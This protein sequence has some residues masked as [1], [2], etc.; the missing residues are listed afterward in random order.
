VTNEALTVPTKVRA[1]QIRPATFVAIVVSMNERSWRGRW[2]V[3]E[4]PEVAV[5]G[6]LYCAED[7]RLRLELVGG[8]DTK[9]RAPLPGGGHTVRSESRD[10]PLI[11]G[12]S[13]SKRFTLIRAHAA[14]T[15]GVGLFGDDIV[16]QTMNPNRVLCGIHLESLG[17]PQFVR[18]HLQLERLLHWSAQS[19]FDLCLLLGENGKSIRE[20]KAATHQVPTVTASFNGM[21]I[22]L[23]VRSTEFYVVDSPVANSRSMEVTERAILD[24][25]TSEPVSFDA[26]DAIGKDMQDLLTLSAYEP[27][28]SRA[29]SL[30]FRAASEARLGVSDTKEVEVMGRQVFQTDLKEKEKQH[31][32]FLFT[33]DDI[34]FSQ[35]VPRWLALKKSASL[36]FNILFGLRYIGSGYVGPRLL[37][38]ATAAENIHRALCSMSAPLPRKTYRELKAKLLGAIVDEP[39]HLREFVNQGLRNDPTYNERML[40]LASIPD[41]ET[42]DKL[43]TDRVEWSKRLK[44][45][46]HDLAHA[47]ER[48]ADDSDSSAALWLLEVTYALLCLVAMSK[49]GLSAEV[50]QRV[51]DNPKIQWASSQFKKVLAI[52]QKSEA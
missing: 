34:E 31:H 21:T 9:I 37:G 46:R 1:A 20:Q 13:G 39:E 48:S 6:T 7:G 17:E 3:P 28:G 10:F 45:A 50:Q 42:V 30:I 43:L 11:H 24:F 27:C 44:N 15:S 36:G 47:N 33:L 32:D 19:T 22:G 40:E 51:F 26:F 49:L 38:V 25:D 16:E 8:F 52:P 18:A 35:L 41:A 14:H 12:A 4:E 5:P 2:W 23:R 29:Q